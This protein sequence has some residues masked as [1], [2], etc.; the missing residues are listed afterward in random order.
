LKAPRY[1]LSFVALSAMLIGVACATSEA[2][3]GEQQPA[4]TNNATEPP[5]KIPESAPPP[6]NKPPEKECTPTCSKDED[7][8]N[9]CKAAPSGAQNC[10]DKKAGKC[11]VNTT[12]VCPKPQEETDSGAPAY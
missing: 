1:L 12:A 7:C 5:S 4:A 2:P 9:T 3:I 11:Y 8:Q 6:A 10:C